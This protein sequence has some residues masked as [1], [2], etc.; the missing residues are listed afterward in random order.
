MDSSRAKLAEVMSRKL[1]PWIPAGK[2]G[3][4]QK[5]RII[6]NP[7]ALMANIRKSN[8]QEHG[9]LVSASIL[10]VNL[11][12]EPFKPQS[13]RQI[14]TSEEST[15]SGESDDSEETGW[16]FHQLG[17]LEFVESDSEDLSELGD[18]DME[19]IRTGYNVVL[20]F[21][22]TG[23]AN[24]VYIIFDW[25]PTNAWGNRVAVED[26]STWGYLPGHHKRVSCGKI[27]D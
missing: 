8:S 14:N 18:Q 7:L 23:K 11:N 27:A 12:V 24:G 3:A 21:S 5:Y 25:Y 15:Q 2:D 26:D 6:P 16:V 13:R 19:W 10:G 17:Y 1:Q 22:N 4:N 9:E 20:R